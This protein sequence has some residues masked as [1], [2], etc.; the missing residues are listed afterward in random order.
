MS[1]NL[2]VV[3]AGLP[4]DDGCPILTR[5]KAFI[6]QEG[7]RATLEHIFR[8]RAGLACDLTPG[9]VQSESSAS[10]GSSDSS[11]TTTDDV[12]T[13]RIREF[14]GPVDNSTVSVYSVTGTISDAAEGAVRAVIPAEVACR[15]GIYQLSWRFQRDG[16]T[17]LINDGLLSV[18]RSLFGDLTDQ[19]LHDGPPTLNEFRMQIMDSGAA[20]NVLLDDVEFDDEQLIIALIKPIRYFNEVPPPLSIQYNTFTFPWYSHWVDAA[21]GYLCQFAAH[22]YRRNRFK[23][24]AGGVT[25]DDKN[26]EREY[27]QQSVLLINEYKEWVTLK[28]CEINARSFVGTVGST[29]GVHY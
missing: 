3:R 8:D 6:V 11:A 19:P 9:Q 23:T 2:E 7:M 24:D 16:E 14:I 15:A 10:S 22:N 5:I 29:Y 25:V 28:K 20:E 4:D 12:V 26:K 13:M 27:L 21:A 17:T 1:A 18:E